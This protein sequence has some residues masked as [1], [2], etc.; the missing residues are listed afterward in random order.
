MAAAQPL[1]IRRMSV[2]EYLA[3]EDTSPVRHE[4]VDGELYAFAGGTWNH[5]EIA[6]NVFATLRL[7][8]RV[9]G[10]RVAISDMRLAVQVERIY[11]YP[12][13][14]VTCEPLNGAELA[15]TQPLLVVEVLSDS[16][17]RTD[18]EAKL[19][20]YR[21]IRSLRHYL[22]VHQN[23]RLVEWHYRTQ[24]D[25]WQRTYV[26]SEGNIEIE[27]LGVTLTLAE[28]YAGTDVV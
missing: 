22:I 24:A 1:P 26:Q 10:C 20:V 25:G 7:A 4:Y 17:Q 5:N 13:V 28:I 27:Q 12:D 2:E 11:Y 3:F 18:H 21:N 9:Q 8:A 14:M 15:A 23:E 6:G 19:M 16:T